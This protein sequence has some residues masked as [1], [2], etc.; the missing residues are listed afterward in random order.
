MWTT[1]EREAKSTHM[2][3]GTCNGGAIGNDFDYCMH[4]IRCALNGCN[5]DE[6]ESSLPVAQWMYPPV[7]TLIGFQ[8]EDSS[9][10][11]GEAMRRVP[12]MDHMLRMKVLDLKGSPNGRPYKGMDL[13][14]PK[15]TQYT[16]LGCKIV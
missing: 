5:W 6:F 4:R 11:N 10:S 9:S 15:V 8:K 3:D 14:H 7:F 16:S 13:M 12:R 2:Q 1:S